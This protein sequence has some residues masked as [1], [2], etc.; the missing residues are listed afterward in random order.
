MSSRQIIMNDFLTSQQM[1]SSSRGRSDKES[2]SPRSAGV[3]GSPA[4]LYYADKEQ[5]QRAEYMSRA[6]PAEHINRYLLVRFVNAVCRS[7]A[8]P[9]KWLLLNDGISLFSTP[10]PHRTPPPQR[11]GVIQRHNTGGSKP[12]SPAPN[13]LHIMPQHHYPL[14][15]M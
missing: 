3:A 10:S 1:T 6:S 9:L 2:P 11:Q 12:P 13:R 8:P 14:S 7:P 15:G 5:R 4:A